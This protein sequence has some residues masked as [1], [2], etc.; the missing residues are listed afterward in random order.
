MRD[1]NQAVSIKSNITVYN[2]V[3]GRDGLIRIK[4]LIGDD[5]C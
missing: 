4:A 1:I 2:K 5:E 3:E